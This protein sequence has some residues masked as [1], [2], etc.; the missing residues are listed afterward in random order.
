MMRN[1]VVFALDVLAAALATVATVIAI[2]GG[3]VFQFSD[4]R[5]S[6]RTPWKTLLWCLFVVVLRVWL[7]R[8]SG[9][10]GRS[11]TCW[12]MVLVASP[13]DDTSGTHRTRSFCR[14]LALA[15]LGIAMALG[16]ILHEQLQDPY[17][18]PDYGDPLFSIWRIGWVLHQL[19][20]DPARLF[21]ANIFFPERL[22]LTFSDPIILPALMSAPLLA[23]GVHPVVAYNALLLSAWWFS[24]IATYLLVERLTGSSRA[25]FIA[26]LMYAFY[27]YRFDHYSH[28]ELQ[29]TF[30]MPLALLALHLFISTQRW[31]YAIALSLA[32]AAQLYSCMY[33]AVFFVPFVAVIAGGLLIAR[34]GWARSLV[35]SVTVAALLAFLIALPLIRA[36]VAA[37]PIKGERPID[38]IRYYSATMSDYL[39]VSKYSAV[40]QG[41]LLPALPERALFPGIAPLAFAALGLV[42]PLSATR[43]AYAAGLAVAVDGSFGLNGAVYPF[44]H[45]WF[46]PVRGLRAPARFGAI[47]GLTLCIIAGFGIRRLLGWCRSRAKAGFVFAG[48]A[49]IVVIDV[50]PTLELTPVWKEP[51]QVYEQ[52]KGLPNVVL[53]EF[54]VD[55]FEHFNLPFMYFSLWHW[56]PLVNGYSG[57]IP[58]SYQEVAPN[59]LKFP[60]GDT[61]N[62]LRRRGVTH[63]TL[64]CA[65]RYSDCKETAQLIRQ[66]PDLRLIA[67]ERWKGE[68][69]ELYELISR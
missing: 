31:R 60:R 3:F 37:Q 50:W 55:A 67:N 17:S 47:V 56:T 68:S 1:R 13:S 33:Y 48:L 34:R 52:L 62:A 44:L 23:A 36:F 5:V 14:D 49:V 64:N 61:P 18:I 24:G 46:L 42:P 7:D 27:Q 30:W 11:F 26:G 6:F 19:L 35:P 32:A 69:V 40:W 29:M 38:E 57:F 41:R 25:A 22:T 54:P 53:A 58:Q 2:N 45:R 9:P 39:R 59:L 43:L 21:D 10:F 63:V 20:R 8:S 66:S 65:L 12:R 15:S 28:L 4:V 51:P 16:L